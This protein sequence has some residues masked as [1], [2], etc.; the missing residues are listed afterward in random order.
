MTPQE[1]NQYFP[2]QADRDLL[3]SRATDM[4]KAVVSKIRI[5]VNGIQSAT[6]VQKR[7]LAR[8]L[9]TSNF[10]SEFAESVLKQLTFD[11]K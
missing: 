4:R 5:V 7:E 3:Q 6:V 2:T 10:D 11:D 8:K 9:A 1:L